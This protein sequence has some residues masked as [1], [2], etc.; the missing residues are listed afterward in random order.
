MDSDR[1]KKKKTSWQNAVIDLEVLNRQISFILGVVFVV[2]SF[3]PIAA[4]KPRSTKAASELRGSVHNQILQ[5]AD[6][7]AD[8]IIN[9]FPNKFR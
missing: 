9:Q 8:G 4:G 7:L 3:V 1:M 2:F 6:M 5:M